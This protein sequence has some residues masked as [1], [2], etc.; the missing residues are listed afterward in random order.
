MKET[1]NPDRTRDNILQAAIEEFSEKGFKGARIVTIAR[2]AGT[3]YQALY[4]HFGDKETLYRAAIESAVTAQGGF[5]RFRF[6]IEEVGPVEAMSRVID[7]IFDAFYQ[8]T[9]SINLIA[10]Q[11]MQKAKQFNQMPAAKQLIQDVLNLTAKI[12]KLGEQQGIFRAGLDPVHVYLMIAGLATSYMTNIHMNKKVFGRKFNSPQE[13]ADW[14][15]HVKQV[16]L[17][18]LGA[19][20]PNSEGPPPTSSR[21]PARTK[22][23]VYGKQ[24]TS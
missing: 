3:N 18:G 15:L 6:P 24:A 5:E 16:V 17:A 14:R 21:P 12:L 19:P 9:K 22:P 23:S 7:G 1:R 4:Y 2:R 20:V 8:N 11:N 13:I 10:D